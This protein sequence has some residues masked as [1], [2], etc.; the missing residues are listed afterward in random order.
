MPETKVTLPL[1]LN[2]PMDLCK[3]RSMWLR[4]LLGDIKFLCDETS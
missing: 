4:A 1:R 3:A 2:K